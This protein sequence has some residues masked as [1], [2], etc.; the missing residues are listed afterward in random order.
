MNYGEEIN[1]EQMLITDN[2]NREGFIFIDRQ[3][4]DSRIRKRLDLL[5]LKQA[6]GNQYKFV[7]AEVKLGNN[8]ELKNDV[9]LQLKGYVSHIQ[10]N[11]KD[12]KKCYETQFEQKQ[13]LGLFEEL[14]FDEIEI[15]NPVEGLVVVGGYSGLAKQQIKILK[16]SHPDIE[17]IHF[18]HEI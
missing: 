12:Y 3:V 16:K 11:F 10:E 13:E 4:T 6:E 1:F 8:K 18:T 15:I 14:K 2:L 7:V 5:G 9:A 17:V